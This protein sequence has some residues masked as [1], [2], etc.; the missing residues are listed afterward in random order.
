ME[1]V[2]DLDSFSKQIAD[3][4]VEHIRS[5]DTVLTIGRSKTVGAFLTAAKKKK[6]A[7]HVI[8]RWVIC[9]CMYIYIHER[10]DGPTDRPSGSFLPAMRPQR[11]SPAV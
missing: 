5:N 2:Q 8:V 6:R 11:G 3:Q 1:L 9:I 10:T 4:A 7:F